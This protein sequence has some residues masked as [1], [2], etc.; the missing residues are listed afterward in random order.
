M[1][2]P[3]YQ[4]MTSLLFHPPLKCKN[5]ETTL[6]D[7]FIG[8]L[9]NE[10][11]IDNELNIYNNIKSLNDIH[12]F[13]FSL[14]F[15]D[16]NFV[17]KC[18]INQD[19]YGQLIKEGLLDKNFNHKYQLI[20]PI[21]HHSKNLIEY[22]LTFNINYNYFRYFDEFSKKQN[23]KNQIIQI[24]QFK[25]LIEALF[26]LYKKIKV[27]NSV[28]FYHNDI[29]LNNILY[30]LHTKEIIFIDLGISKITENEHNIFD[31]TSFLMVVLEI[32]YASTSNQTIFIETQDIIKQI[33]HILNDFK[34]GLHNELLNEEKIRI[35]D[36]VMDEI[37]QIN[38]F[39]KEDIKNE[40][41]INIPLEKGRFKQLSYK[42]QMEKA[43]I[44]FNKKAGRKTGKKIRQTKKKKTNKFRHQGPKAGRT[45]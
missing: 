7:D 21:F 35:I 33:E 36:S 39:G 44:T 6:T 32:L 37:N 12:H 42:Q 4:T 28:G 3:K 20:T 31:L 5:D 1:Y 34:I 17:K 22:L 24:S 27:L 30:N 29:K 10:T 25:D 14:P 19:V 26:D 43:T 15:L 16:Y 11:D 8:K 40:E 2:K 13:S 18:E 45:P 38:W 23:D 41:I 9:T